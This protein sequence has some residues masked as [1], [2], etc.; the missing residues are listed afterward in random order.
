MLR[1]TSPD[2]NRLLE[3]LRPS[4]ATGSLVEGRLLTSSGLRHLL[5]V[6]ART[7]AGIAFVQGD[8]SEELVPYQRVMV[9]ARAR[10]STLRRHGLRQ[11]EVAILLA[12]DSPQFVF[13]FWACILGGIIP[14]PLVCPASLST[15][16][17]PL[18]KLLAVWAHLGR[19]P[20]IADKTVAVASAESHDQLEAARVLVP[21]RDGEAPP[22]DPAPLPD[23]DSPA[24]IRFSSGSTGTPKGVVLSHRN[25]LTNIEAIIDGLALATDDRFASW[26]PYHHDMGLIG[27]HLTPIAVNATQVNINPFRFVKQPIQWLRKM[28]QQRTAVTGSPNFGY[29]RVR[30]KLTDEDVRTLDLGWLR[31][32]VNGAEPISCRVMRTFMERLGPAGLSPTAM[33]PVYGMAEASLAVPFPPLGE[34]SRT[35]SLDRLH[36]AKQGRV[37]EVPEEAA[38]ALTLVDEGVPLHG[39]EVRIVNDSDRVVPEGRVGHIQIRGDNVT[40]GYYENSAA[41][42]ELFCDRWLRTGDLGFMLGGRL[43]V[44]GRSKD[45]LFVNGQNFFA[46]DVEDCAGRVQ[47][48]VQGVA[49]RR[50]VA[51]GWH[52][53]RLG[54]EQIA[55]FVGLEPEHTSGRPR[56]EVFRDVW[57]CVA[58]TTGVQVDVIVPL[59]SIPKTTSGKVQRYKLLQELLDGAYDATLVCRAA[60]FQT[61]GAEPAGELTPAEATVRRVFATVL[62]LAPEQVPLDATFRALGGSSIKAV[63]LLAALEATLARTLPQRML[64]E[65]RTAREVA[66]FV[67]RERETPAAAAG[68]RVERAAVD[69]SLLDVAIVGLGARFP[70]AAE[71]DGFW[72]MLLTGR[73]AIGEVPPDRWA[74]GELYRGPEPGAGRAASGG[75]SS[76]I[77]TPSITGTSGSRPRRP[78]PW[79]PSNASSWRWPG[80]RW[81]RAGAPARGRGASGSASSWA[82]ATAST[83]ERLRE[84]LEIGRR[85]GGVQV[86]LAQRPTTPDL[87]CHVAAPRTT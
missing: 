55:L 16:S 39:C 21:D 70:G 42:R 3:V 50:V 58:D 20:I 63:E 59:R 81:R 30:E 14:A 25:L 23:L 69:A 66:R 53:P 54:R 13:S 31:A 71:A 83:S 33:F 65:C 2:C 76:T 64:V 1:D 47:G 18:R 12:G 86:A 80:A 17:E 51:V 82:P 38:T 75:P 74:V 27:F 11:G 61:A 34:V 32:I 77:R 68:P 45:I 57:L 5:E 79:I 6:A 28:Q 43:T 4:I 87:R 24:F 48:G 10:L 72:E 26:M 19:A 22:A 84:P 35:R 62:N 41:N 40:R 78:P 60:L 49:D 67:D 73:S 37:A 36:L 56:E 52:E 7:P 9:E 8:W 29:L 44:T 85:E 15:P 46:F